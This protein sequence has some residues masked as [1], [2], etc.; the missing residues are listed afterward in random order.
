MPSF[1]YAQEKTGRERGPATKLPV[2][3]EF[4]DQDKFCLGFG[5]SHDVFVDL[6]FERLQVIRRREHITGKKIPFPGC[7]RF[8]RALRGNSACTGEVHSIR[9][10]SFA[11]PQRTANLSRLW[12][13]LS[14]AVSTMIVKVS[15]KQR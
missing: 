7:L 8:E 13:Q 6:A 4:L 3:S 14:N 15:V 10:P 2:N 11:I 5:G 9:V 1:F 12:H